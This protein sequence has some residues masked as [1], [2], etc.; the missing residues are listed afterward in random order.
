[1][2]IVLLL[3]A[4][5]Y[6]VDTAAYLDCFLRV[7]RVSKVLTG[8]FTKGLDWRHNSYIPGPILGTICKHLELDHSRGH[9]SI[10]KNINRRS[11]KRG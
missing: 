6:M 1:M 2:K 4:E 9:F 10:W 11:Y 7:L 8:V 5:N 3:R